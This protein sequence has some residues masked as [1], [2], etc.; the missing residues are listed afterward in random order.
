MDLSKL[1]LNSKSRQQIEN[2]LAQPT[3]A[4]LL[5]GKNG[6]GLDSTAKAIAK[7]LAD[8]QVII[9]QPRLHD[10]QKTL[11]ININDIHALID[12][13]RSRRKDKLAIVIE[14]IESMTN[15]APQAFLKL[16]EEPTVNIFYILSSHSVA[17]LPQTI[18]SRV[19]N[20]ELLPVPESDLDVLFENSVMRLAKDRRTR[21]L[22]LAAGLPA[23]TLRLIQDEQYYRE[24]VSL[25]EQA[26]LF[27][28]GK[29]YDRL[30]I[31]S[32]IKD[33]KTAVDL[34][35]SISRIV[36]MTAPKSKSPL[37]TAQQL[38]ILGQAID[39]LNQNGNVRAQLVSIAL[40]L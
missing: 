21:I 35:Y 22:F 37:A 12:L 2:Y 34:L 3:H 36:A 25:F 33:R 23:E 6:I 27:V 7:Q 26:K 1:I 9:I 24:R 20:I 11:S 17:R 31:T 19:Q 18:L 29:E 14:N 28:Q 15:D 32:E 5:T 39:N 10:K 4:L 8:N 40:N 13:T 38:Q 30:K 16:L